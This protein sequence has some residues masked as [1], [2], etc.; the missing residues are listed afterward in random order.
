MEKT[1]SNRVESVN[2]YSG[3]GSKREE[4]EQMFNNISPRYDLLNSLLSIGIDKVWR[5]KLSALVDLKHPRHILDV[6][7]GTAELALTLARDTEAKIKGVDISAGMIEIGRKKVLQR[8]LHNRIDLIEA[9]SLQLPFEDSTF[10]AVTVAFGVRNFA[11][12][13][14]GIT[15]ML[16]VLKPGH[17][18][19]VLEF[20]NTKGTWINPLFTFYFRFILPAIGRLISKDK[21]A[22]E[23]LPNSVAAFPT[24]KEFCELLLFCGASSVKMRKLTAGIVTIYSA[25]KKSV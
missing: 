16:R 18:L 6:A 3:S 25:E 23:Y 12:L 1:Y 5:N 2:P 14:K 15:E 10:D 8:K 20:S 7:T 11:S 24:G 21:S 9:D 4:I 17:S 22:Y 19:F 13:E